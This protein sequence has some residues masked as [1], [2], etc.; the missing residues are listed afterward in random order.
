ML[1]V[2]SLSDSD[3]SGFVC[4]SM[5]RP[6]APHAIA[7][8]LIGSTKFL[9]P[10]AWLGSTIIGKCVFSFSAGTIDRSSVFL[11]YVL[12]VL[13][14]LSQSIILSFP[15][16]A[17]YSA[18]LR[19]SSIVAVS[20]LFKSTGFFVFPASFSREKFCMFRAPICI[21]SAYFSTSFISLVSIASVTIGSPVSFFAAAR[22]FSPS[23]PIPWNE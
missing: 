14:P 5:I 19:N 9:I 15:S 4:A 11:V 13:I 12:N 18:A 10:V 1:I 7:A 3:F 20:P 22:N 16:A 6:S 8:L 23:S 17:I 21:M 2:C